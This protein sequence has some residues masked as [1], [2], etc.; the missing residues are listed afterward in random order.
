V[1]L[2][3]EEL[4]AQQSQSPLEEY[5]GTDVTGNPWFALDVTHVD[6]GLVNGLTSE[7][8]KF[9]EARPATLGF[10]LFEAA[11]FSHGRSIIDWNARNKFCPACGSRNYSLWSGW[12][13]A[14][15]SLLPWN[16][17]EGQPPCPSGKGLNNYTHPRT[18]MAVI[19]TIV[20]EGRGKV[21]LGRG[22][23]YPPL[24]YSALAGFLEP[25]ETFE[26]AVRREIWEESG[27]KVNE[28]SYH[29]C[30]PWPYPSTLMIGFFASADSTKEINLG[31][32]NELADA[33]WYTREEVL[34]VLAHP[35]GIGFAPLDP[36]L[37]YPEFRIPPTTA[38]AGVM[39]SQWA[40][41][42]WKPF[43]G[44]VLDAEAGKSKI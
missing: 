13:V 4:G 18:D 1:F 26:E 23:R 44:A 15:T 9:V 32:D 31:L 8:V 21:L 22:K 11:V 41:G 30:Q 38:I 2:G 24:S 20:D 10:N 39:I 16:V 40:R 27:V 28:V 34:K 19:T 33:K 35:N 17:K 7:N 43:G 37:E 36:K 42:E 14:C 3:I 25:S 6:A 5:P 29:S 12:K